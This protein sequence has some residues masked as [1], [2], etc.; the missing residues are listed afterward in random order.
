[1]ADYDGDLTLDVE[2]ARI[3]SNVLDLGAEKV[4]RDSSSGTGSL[5]QRAAMIRDE[6]LGNDS[7]N[8]DSAH[9]SPSSSG[10]SAE[11]LDSSSQ[12]SELKDEQADLEERLNNSAISHSL[13]HIAMAFDEKVSLEFGRGHHL[14]KARTQPIALHC[15]LCPAPHRV[16][17][18]R[19]CER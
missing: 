8:P 4:D 9:E 2:Q 11:E 3:A 10:T 6:L 12:K 15:S 18:S 5:T 14:S 19:V 1:M 7:L 13:R 16:A 17:S